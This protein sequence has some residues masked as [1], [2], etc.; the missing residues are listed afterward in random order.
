M[1][2]IYIPNQVNANWGNISKLLDGVADGS[3]VT[4]DRDVKAYSKN[5]GGDGKSTIVANHNKSGT[6]TI[7]Y[8]SGAPILGKLNDI[9]AANQDRTDGALVMGDLYIEDFSGTTKAIGVDAVI[10]GINP[11]DFGT[12]ESDMTVTW[13]VDLDV[14]GGGSKDVRAVSTIPI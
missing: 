1:T 8:R 7:T 11:V 13:L 10:E 2:Q 14:S 5:T 12:D 4:A 3:F 9:A 6:I